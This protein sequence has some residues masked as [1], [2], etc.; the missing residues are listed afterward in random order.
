MTEQR[1][2]KFDGKYVKFT[3]P[4]FKHAV[5]SVE[6]LGRVELDSDVVETH[7]NGILIKKLHIGFHLIHPT[8]E[9]E[10]KYFNYADVKLIENM[11]EVHL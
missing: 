4:Q 3:K 9:R 10:I 7:R 5:K 1:L 8:Q 6:Y 2:K 11:E